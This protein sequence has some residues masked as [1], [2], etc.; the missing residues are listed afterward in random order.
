LHFA[1]S[2]ALC[3][4]ANSPHHSIA[5]RLDALQVRLELS[6]ADPRNLATDTAQILG[7]T[8]PGNLVPNDRLLATN[9]T[10]HGHDKT[11]WVRY[12]NTLGQNRKYI[13][14]TNQ[15]L[16]G[17]PEHGGEWMIDQF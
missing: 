13:D 12:C 2:N 9:L 11:P 8:A 7:L 6:P 3:A 10:L 4:N 1:A 16:V 15:K 14:I 17:N 5:Y